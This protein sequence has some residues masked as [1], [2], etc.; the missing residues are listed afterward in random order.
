MRFGIEDTQFPIFPVHFIPGV[1]W[2]LRRHFHA[3]FVRHAFPQGCFNVLLAHSLAHSLAGSLAPS[4]AG[5]ASNVETP[6]AR[7]LT[8]SLA[9]SLACS[10]AR[11][12]LSLEF[13]SRVG[14]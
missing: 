13:R 3:P 8:R 10:L 11:A 14:P 4:D 1:R 5:G 6:L 2:H 12:L 9:P 7:S